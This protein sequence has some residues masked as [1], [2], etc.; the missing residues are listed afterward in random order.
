MLTITTNKDEIIEIA[1]GDKKAK[2][3]P[4]TDF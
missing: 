2:A 1:A 4:L 3:L